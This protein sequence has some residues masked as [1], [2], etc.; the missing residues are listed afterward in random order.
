MIDLAVDPIGT[1]HQSAR[2]FWCH[3]PLVIAQVMQKRAWVCP[4]DWRRQVKHALRVKVVG[5]EQAKLLGVTPGTD[6][7]LDVPLPAQAEIE[8]R[9]QQFGVQY[10]GKR[11]NLTWGGQ[12]GPGKTYGIRQFL[13][14]RSLATSKHEALLLRENWEQLEKTHIR[15][16]KAELPLLGAQLVDRTAQFANGAYID[17]GHMAD[18]EAVNRYLSTGYGVIAPDEASR[19]PINADGVTVLSELATRARESWPDLHGRNSV[20]LFIP[21]TNPGGPSA[22]WLLDMCIDH[23]PDLEQ[24]PALAGTNADGSPVYDVAHWQ[25]QAASL[26]DNPYMRPDYATTDL[27]GLAKWRYEQ[28]RH[29]DWH[30]FSGQ[31]FSQWSESTHVKD[32]QIPD[33]CLWFTSMD[34]GS[35]QPGCVGYYV[36]LPDR[37]IY[38]RAEIKFQHAHVVDVIA[39]MKAR[40]AEL[41]ITGKISYR[42]GDPAMGIASANSKKPHGESI[43]DTF[44]ANGIVMRPADNERVHG[45]TRCLQLLRKAP[46]GD[47]WFLVHSDCRYF[48]RTIAAACSD[49]SNPDDVDTTCDDHALDEWRYG[50]MSRPSP[51]GTRQHEKKTPGSIGWWKDRTRPKQGLL[52]RGHA[53]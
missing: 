15:K 16:M 14:R 39:L 7:C 35:N 50:M 37:R 53:A 48:I 8:E 32:L 31:F 9:V 52:S 46:D 3:G 25:Y 42:M 19:Y 30:V 26:D 43:A 45:W 10:P 33:G 49:K 27:A 1:P 23:T 20:P 47:P 2:C 38:R 13:Y 6:V 22:S 18:A 40:E 41:G 21:V 51:L 24:F 4:V 36:V 12:A 5:K 17:C 28:L 11:L 29:G 44:R 34:W